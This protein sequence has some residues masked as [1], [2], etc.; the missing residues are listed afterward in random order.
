MKN[1][2]T[3]KCRPLLVQEI[4]GMISWIKYLD[5][6]AM[7]TECFIVVEVFYGILTD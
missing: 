7:L 5:R 4:K 3:L 1:T 6:S 2:N